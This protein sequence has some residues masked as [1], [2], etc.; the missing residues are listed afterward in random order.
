[1]IPISSFD[2]P[3]LHFFTSFSRMASSADETYKILEEVMLVLDLSMIA[4]Y[5]DVHGDKNLPI[6]RMYLTSAVSPIIGIAGV[7][8]KPK[9]EVSLDYSMSTEY[10]CHMLLKIFFNET[11]YIQYEHKNEQCCQLIKKVIKNKVLPKL[12]LYLDKSD[13]HG[14]F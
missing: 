3:L 9:E 4:M 6:L 2:S 8:G 13:V 5:L 1:M 14:Y 12:K 11:Q 10:Q 7:L